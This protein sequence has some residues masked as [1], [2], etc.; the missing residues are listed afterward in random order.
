MGDL[1]QRGVAGDGALSYELGVAQV[2]AAKGG[3][4]AAPS[5]RGGT[6]EAEA[7]ITNK[8]QG[9]EGGARHCRGSRARGRQVKTDLASQRK[10]S[11]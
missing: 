10:T 8:C 3:H 1:S 7:P 2:P 9:A 6:D 4:E 11:Q 5:H